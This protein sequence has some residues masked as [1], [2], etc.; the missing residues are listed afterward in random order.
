MLVAE[1]DPPRFDR[2]VVRWAARFILEAPGIAADEA[3]LA[4][5]CAPKGL[6]DLR[7]RE[8]AAPPRSCGVSPRATGFAGVVG[9]L[10]LN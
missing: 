8:L 5:I 10:R 2:A 6:G 4:S 7:T 1:A 3:A 9:P